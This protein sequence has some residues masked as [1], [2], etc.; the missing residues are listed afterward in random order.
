M[1]FGQLGLGIPGEGAP[2]P[3]KGGEGPT[4]GAARMVHGKTPENPMQT[5]R[6]APGW[7]HLDK[8]GISN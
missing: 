8:Q 7:N 6:A 3:W 4:G 1:R 5:G 2:A